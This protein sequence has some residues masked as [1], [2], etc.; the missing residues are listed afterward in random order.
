MILE[1]NC[2]G[3][4]VFIVFVD[5]GLVMGMIGILIGLV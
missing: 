2:L 4:K 5:V 3:V 1:Y